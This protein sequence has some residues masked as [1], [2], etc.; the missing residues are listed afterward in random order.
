[1]KNNSLKNKTILLIN[2]GSTHKRHVLKRLKQLELN[3]I[4]LNPEK[5]WAQP[6]VDKWIITNNYDHNQA[7]RDLD[8]FLKENPQ[9][10]IDG[11]ITFWEDDVLLTSKIVDKYGFIGIPLNIAQEVRNK[12]EFRKFCEKNNLP[13]PKFKSIK[14]DQDLNDVIKTFKFPLVIKPAFGS[15]SNYVVKVTNKQELKSTYNYIKNNLSTT[16]ESALN[17]GAEVFIEEYIEGDEVDVDMLL[18]NGKVKFAVVSDN[19]DKTFDEFF[20]DMGQSAPSSLSEET[21]QKIIEMCEDTLE[22]LGIFNGCIHYEAK[23]TKNGP[24]PIEVNLRMGGDYVWSYIKDAWDVDLIENAVKIALGELIKFP[25]KIKPRKYVIG[26]DLHP[27][28]SGILA[29][30]DIPDEFEQQP[31]LEDLTMYKQI[32][33]AVMVPPEATETIGWLTVSGENFLDAQDNLQ[34]ALENLTFKVAKFDAESSLG[35][36]IRKNRFAT[37]TFNK[38]M[39]IKQARIAK[40]KKLDKAD[41]KNIKIGLACNLNEISTDPIEIDLTN[42]AKFVQSTL[43]QA[44]YNVELLNIND[45]EVF[46]NQLKPENNIDLILNLSKKLNNST[47]LGTQTPTFFE[48]S[49]IPYIGSNTSTNIL[50]KDKIKFKKILEYHEIPTP[51]WDYVYS[52]DESIDEELEY[53]L[54]VKPANH[55]YSFGI[56]NDSVVKNQ[57]ELKKQIKRIL[58]TFNCPVLV[59]EYIEGDEIRVSIIG[60]GNDLQILPISRTIFDKMSPSYQHIYTYVAKWGDDPE[61]KNLIAQYPVK[62]INKKLETLISEIALD[63]YNITRSKDYACIEF[64]IDENNNPYVIEIDPNPSLNQSSEL[65]KVGKV[66]EIEY[67]DLLEEIILTAITRY[68][69]TSGGSV[70]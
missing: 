16:I 21:Q 57:A 8:N 56:T 25:K 2:T 27:D 13:F 39:L 32:G 7:L 66:A 1:M 26:W 14:S 50:S 24:F 43:K 31:Y 47:L 62:N 67:L 23:S 49:N 55:D 6:Y 37:A 9:I 38:Q 61:Y 3:I 40:F 34:S 11:V 45:F 19:F 63:T 35:K 60:N 12:L 48:A 30:L 4:A 51:D 36:T 65:S 22:K 17:D 28:E 42:T 59:E 68:R 52:L 53:P 54:I 64:R 33:E 10:K 46:T 18:Q 58:T 15:Q 20:I 5:N 70:I 69:T 41:L 29:E 44:N